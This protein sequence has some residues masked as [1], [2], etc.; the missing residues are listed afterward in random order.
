[1]KNIDGFS[2]FNLKYKLNAESYVNNNIRQLIQFMNIE[3][4]DYESLD[5]IK[6]DL[7]I[8]FTKY[9]EQISKYQLKTTGYPKHFNLSTNNIGGVIK[10]R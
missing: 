10:Y 4:D 3:E 7:I 1:M 8:Y 2:E 6:N 5:D 9:P